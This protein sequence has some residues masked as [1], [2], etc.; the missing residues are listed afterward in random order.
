MLLEDCKYVKNTKKKTNQTLLTL[1][2]LIFFSIT[3]ITHEYAN[4]LSLKNF[5]VIES[6]KSS[7]T[8][9]SNP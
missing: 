2:P 3:K 8:N 9:H 4:V 7:V 1:F 5:K 6:L